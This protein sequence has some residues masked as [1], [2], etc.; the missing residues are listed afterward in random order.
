[1]KKYILFS[2]A[3]LSLALTACEDEL[4]KINKQ[5]D[6]PSNEMISPDL[7]ITDG[8]M[9]TG[10]TTSSGA[11]AWYVS[12]YTEQ[13]VGVGYNQLY[14]A[15][16]RN[17]STTAS[18]STFN[19]EWNGT[20]GNILNLK[21]ALE[22]AEEGGAYSTQVDTRGIIKTMLALNY[23]ILT[24]MFGDIPCSEAGISRQPKLDSQESVYT[25]IFSLLNSAITDFTTA[26]NEG[27]SYAGSHD[28][29][30]GGK[31]EKWEAFAY[32][33][34]ARY[35]LHLMH[36][37]SNAQAEALA[38]AKQAKS[39]GFEGAEITGFS[40]YSSNSSN[41]WAAFW[42][43]RN[44]NAASK[45]VNDML[46]ERN[47]PRQPVYLAPWTYNGA[48][49]LSDQ[50]ATPGNRED[51]QTTYGTAVGEGFAVPAWLNAYEY[52]SAE[53]ASIHLLS[54]SELYFIL[55]ELEQRT[56]ADYT[57]DLTTAIEASFADYGQFGIEVN[58]TASDYVASLSSKLQ[59]NAL[60]EI[61]V[62]K[63]IS[64]CRDEQLETYNDFRRMD[65]LGDAD[66]YVA[67]TNGYNTQNGAN[68]WPLRLPYGNSDVV[69]NPN[70]K[71]AYGD[72]T[73]VFTSN[74]WWAN[75]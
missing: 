62:Q 28:I 67:K 63:Y 10:F 58:G 61:M 75:K 1:M 68:R 72:G 7:Q 59:A 51:A 60:K 49:V 55:A 31:M 53:S 16:I 17:I 52:P 34:I 6:R 70:V 73:Y 54:K 3:A 29:L 22:K 27:I 45:T 21:L 57:A 11:L 46:V 5:P 56:G 69:A 2:L 13:L 14:N 20:Y 8:I 74:V 4:D 48:Q 42:K 50:P 47:D 12:S 9:S 33:L 19:N 15:E 23:G 30:Y 39:L 35:K 64:Q 40:S 18:S 32:A 41:P 65:A 26:K 66:N 44:Y 71:A 24:D 38:A 37:D 36:V 43:D 25:E